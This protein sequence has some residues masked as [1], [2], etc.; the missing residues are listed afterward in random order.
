M[1]SIVEL[2][3]RALIQVGQAPITDLAEN[4]RRAQ[5]CA[6]EF[7]DTLDELIVEHPWNP[8]QVRTSLVALA[9]APA[10]DYAYAFELPADPYSL[11]VYETSL[12]DG[13]RWS[14]EGR[15]LVADSSAV[16][17]LYGGRPASTQIL[18][19]LMAEALVYRLAKKIAF[20]LTGKLSVT[21][22]MQKLYTLALAAARFADG[23]ESSPR[24]YR[25]STLTRVRT[26]G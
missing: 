25:T 17:I 20:P 8:T 26:S 23:K 22:A 9:E 12:Q 16:S 10:F 1:A 6:A 3:S 15:T 18:S 19:P 24:S 5:T 21:E 2:C 7:R 13:E 4:N 14:I 11:V